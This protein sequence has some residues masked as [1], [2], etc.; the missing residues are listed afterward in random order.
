MGQKGNVP[1]LKPSLEVGNQ[2][3]TV[4]SDH[5]DLGEGKIEIGHSR[6]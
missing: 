3:L 4:I 5:L 2:K 1:F 6:A